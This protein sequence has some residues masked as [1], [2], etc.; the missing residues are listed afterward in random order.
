MRRRCNCLK[1]QQHIHENRAGWHRNS[2]PRF[3]PR[4]ACPSGALTGWLEIDTAVCDA[5]AGI[6]PVER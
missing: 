4:W 1:L 2:P 6:A 3:R 5:P